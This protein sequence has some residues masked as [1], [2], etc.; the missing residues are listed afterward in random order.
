MDRDQLDLAIGFE[1]LVISMRNDGACEAETCRL[2]QALLHIGDRAALTRQTQLA[3]GDKIVGNGAI[4]DRGDQR[5][6]HGKVDRRLIKA[7]P[8]ND[9]QKGIMRGEVKP[10][11]LFQYRGDQAHRIVVNAA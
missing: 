8:S 6:G 2:L 1:S 4:G 11:A 7:K 9:V 5:Q 10:K 3:D